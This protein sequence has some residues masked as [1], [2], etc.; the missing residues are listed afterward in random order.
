M[1]TTIIV[2]RRSSKLPVRIPAVGKVIDSEAAELR[3]LQEKFK[4]TTPMGREIMRKVLGRARRIL[5]GSNS[6]NPARS[7]S[8]GVE[9]T[10]KAEPSKSNAP[11]QAPSELPPQNQ[12]SVLATSRQDIGPQRVLSPIRPEDLVRS[13]GG[14]GGGTAMPSRPTISAPQATVAVGTRQSTA[15]PSARPPDTTDHAPGS[16]AVPSALPR[17]P[18]AQANL[19]VTGS[20]IRGYSMAEARRLG[21][22]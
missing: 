8:F 2:R 5:F 6:D 21:L 9:Q 18:Q 20:S 17:N 1:S 12:T 4:G 16:A 3:R 22:V 13:A 11:G 15:D 19:P 7:G 14:E 10:A